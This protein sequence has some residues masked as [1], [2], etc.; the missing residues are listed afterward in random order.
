MTMKKLLHSVAN[1][2]GII[3]RKSLQKS[4]AEQGHNLTGKALMSIDYTTDY[5]ESGFTIIMWMVH[6]GA[7]LDKGILA[8]NIPFGQKKA[9]Y[10]KYIQ[11]LRD[12]VRKRMRIGGKRGLSIAF[13]IA[14]TQKKEGM[15][16]RNSRK[17]SKT[18]RRKGFVEVAIQAA[19]A[20]T[21]Q[22]VIEKTNLLLIQ[23]IAE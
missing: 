17:F 22:A 7:I 4:F 1:A 23:I 3:N 10:S 16:T 15:P 12:Y 9:A 19:A 21:R 14:K 5:T 18:G 6:Y 11:G 2:I 13:A 20:K 8:Q